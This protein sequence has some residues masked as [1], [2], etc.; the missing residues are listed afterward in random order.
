[1]VTKDARMLGGRKGVLGEF[2]RLLIWTEGAFNT[3]TRLTVL[4]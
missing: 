3:S 2:S 1:M 4:S